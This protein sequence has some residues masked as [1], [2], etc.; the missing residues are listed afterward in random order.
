MAFLREDWKEGG[1]R[2]SL[3]KAGRPWAGVGGGL[4]GTG[5]WVWGGEASRG[6]RAQD[7]IARAWGLARGCSEPQP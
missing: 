6:G 3:S 4:G 5:Q 7:Q 1:R 2:G